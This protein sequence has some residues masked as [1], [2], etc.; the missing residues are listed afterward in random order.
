MKCK[1]Q[2]VTYGSVT[3]TASIWWSFLLLI[4]WGTYLTQAKLSKYELC[5]VLTLVI[6]VNAVG[7]V[8]GLD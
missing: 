3:S 5:K 6:Y 2:K 1:D 4:K 8:I 7:R